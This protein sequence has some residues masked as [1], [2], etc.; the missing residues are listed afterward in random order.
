MLK[1]GRILL[2]AA[3]LLLVSCGEKPAEKPRAQT[4]KTPLI[5][6]LFFQE[7]IAAQLNFPF[8]FSDSLVREYGIETLTWT[9]YGSTELDEDETGRGTQQEGAQRTMTVYTFDRSGM[10]IGLERKHFSEGLTISTSRYAIIP[11]KAAGY[12]PIKRVLPIDL[13]SESMDPGTSATEPFSFLRQVTNRTRILQYDDDF[14][15]VRYHFFPEKK[16]RGPLSIDSIGHPGSADWIVWGTPVRPEKRYQVR[17]T[18]TER[19]VTH[20]HYLQDNYP[21]TITWSDYPFTQKRYFSYSKSGIFTGFIDSTF[22]DN[23]FVTRNVT[24]FDLDKH[25]SPM[26]ITHRK[27]HADAGTNY[28]TVEKISYTYFSN[29]K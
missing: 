23:A 11:T 19:N 25:N 21:S 7:E 6:P 27:G 24:W 9:V 14:T 26:Q 20:Y 17:N 29:G 16:Y 2:P 1:K 5:H 8:W 13:R 15:D 10:L 28:Q 3:L 18:V 22:I 12:C 4:V